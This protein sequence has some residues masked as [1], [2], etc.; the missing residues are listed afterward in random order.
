MLPLAEVCFRPIAD[1]RLSRALLPDVVDARAFVA[2]LGW[3]SGNSSSAD[4]RR[5][6]WRYQPTC[7]TFSLS[8]SRRAG[9]VLDAREPKRAFHALCIGS[10]RHLYVVAHS[11]SLVSAFHPFLP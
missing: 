3:S 7:G 9:G 8:T 11:F 1:I 6:D 2:R 10:R 5:K 4:W